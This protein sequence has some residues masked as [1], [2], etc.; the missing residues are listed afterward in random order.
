[1]SR[2]YRLGQLSA[3]SSS[4]ETLYC[5]TIRTF[6]TFRNSYSELFDFRYSR[7]F[8]IWVFQKPEILV[9][10][11]LFDFVSKLVHVRGKI[12]WESSPGYVIHS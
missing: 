7:L 10:E 12:I 5:L 4:T 6:S 9:N 1:M 3:D 8:A 11:L 2:N